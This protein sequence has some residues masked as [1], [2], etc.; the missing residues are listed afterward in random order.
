MARAMC[1]V[2]HCGVLI[3]AMCI[4]LSHFAH[5]AV[6][7]NASQTRRATRHLNINNFL[8]V[9][10]KREDVRYQSRIKLEKTENVWSFNN[11]LTKEP[12]A[13]KFSDLSEL[14]KCDQ[15]ELEGVTVDQ[16]DCK[17]L[18][19]FLKPDEGAPSPD[20]GTM[21]FVYRQSI[22]F[23]IKGGFF[24]SSHMS[25]RLYDLS[26]AATLE[27]IQRQIGHW[28]ATEF[29]NK[30]HDPPPGQY[31]QFNRTQKGSANS[32]TC[33]IKSL[34]AYDEPTAMEPESP[35]GQNSFQN[36]ILNLI[37]VLIAQDFMYIVDGGTCGSNAAPLGIT[38]NFNIIRQSEFPFLRLHHDMHTTPLAIFWT[39]EANV[40][41][42]SLTNLS[43]DPYNT[44]VSIKSLSPLPAL[45]FQLNQT[46]QNEIDNSIEFMKFVNTK[47][48]ALVDAIW[49]D[50]DFYKWFK[51]HSVRPDNATDFEAIYMN[52]LEDPRILLTF[53][54]SKLFLAENMPN[55]ELLDLS[56]LLQ[57]PEDNTTREQ[58]VA[59]ARTE[60]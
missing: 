16:L 29:Y 30:L 11:P 32:V 2:T 57:A 15:L 17:P 7:Y 38:F 56:Q 43:T 4:F 49:K 20:D 37:E 23:K 19:H 27:M 48:V 25:M 3:A 35:T 18:S 13:V 41:Q 46:F 44:T 24:G 12:L 31:V 59:T 52:K 36:D 54:I 28:N 26:Q 5:P 55:F 1:S 34:F 14:V 33:H 45:S 10:V 50:G 53:N 22:W 9:D 42:Q 39:Y 6:A 8:S 40:D 51:L 21:R 60:L 47:F 58:D